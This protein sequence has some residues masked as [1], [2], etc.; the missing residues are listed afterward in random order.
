MVSAVGNP[1]L[2][3]DGGRGRER[4]EL[5]RGFVVFPSEVRLPRR[6]AAGASPGWLR[7][8]WIVIAAVLVAAAVIAAA[9]I[10]R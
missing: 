4:A 10:V 3:G 2:S 1:D 9:L 5:P 8:W 7:N 6:G